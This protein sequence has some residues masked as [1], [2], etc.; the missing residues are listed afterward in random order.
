MAA[1]NNNMMTM[2]CDDVGQIDNRYMED[3]QDDDNDAD[4]CGMN[5]RQ[6]W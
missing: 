5:A 2:V 6:H 1:T 4:L 3:D